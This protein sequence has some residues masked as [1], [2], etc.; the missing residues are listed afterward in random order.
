[1]RASFSSQTSQSLIKNQL[2]K[3]KSRSDLREKNKFTQYDEESDEESLDNSISSKEL[4][5]NFSILVPSLISCI[6]L[7]TI[8]TYFYAFST[9]SIQD[10]SNTIT[11]YFHISFAPVHGLMHVKELYYSEKMIPLP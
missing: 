8:S 10:L 9:N 4:C 7:I 2:N 6:L 3:N 1:M 11:A 5:G